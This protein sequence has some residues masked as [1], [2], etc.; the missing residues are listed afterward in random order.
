MAGKLEAAA[1]VAA[2]YCMVISRRRFQL[3]PGKARRGQALVE[4][5]C[6]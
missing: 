6:Q 4:V 2:F 3:I 5:R 1:R